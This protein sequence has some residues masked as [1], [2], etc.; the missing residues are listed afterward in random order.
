MLLFTNIHAQYKPNKA[1]D[2]RQ[3]W[4]DNLDQFE[5]ENRPCTLPCNSHTTHITSIITFACICIYYGYYTG[6]V[7]L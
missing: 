2:I 7:R 3:L 4:L 5:G 6:T 1:N